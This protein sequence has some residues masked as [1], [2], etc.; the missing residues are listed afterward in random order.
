MRSSLRF[1][2]LITRCVGIVTRPLHPLMLALYPAP[3]LVNVTVPLA[4]LGQGFHGYRIAFL[5]DLHSGVTT[6][7]PHLSLAVELVNRLEPDLVALG[8]D[9]VFRHSAAI[10]P[11]ARLIGRLRAA[12]GVYAVFGNHDHR[13]NHPRLAEALR[14]AG[15]VDLTNRGVRLARA[16]S[17][18]WLCG[19]DDAQEGRPDTEAA[20]AGGGRQE[21]TIMLSHN[22]DLAE[23]VSPDRTDLMLSG[24]THSGQIRL[25]VP[26]FTNS[27]FG[28]RYLA[29]L[30]QSGGCLVYVSAGLGAVEIP[31]RIG[32]PPEISV[33][34]LVAS[35][36]SALRT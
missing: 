29:G 30:C 3:R 11:V 15:V 4:R 10:E 13:V 9:Y 19:V 20:L 25:G 27:R 22:P 26:L 1:Q 36:S 12:E 16:G 18:V 21:C 17:T 31:L 33:I 28:R 35:G 32:S 5:S 34:R 6:P 14:A 2:E 24:H 8:G 7:A 23:C